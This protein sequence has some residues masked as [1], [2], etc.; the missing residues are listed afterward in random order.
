[1]EQAK[2]PRQEKAP[3]SARFK[4]GITY[5]VNGGLQQI[6]SRIDQLGIK[7][8]VDKMGIDRF[9]NQ[10]A[11]LAAGSGVVTG[12]GGFATMLIGVPV[13]V[14]NVITQQ[15]RVTLAITYHVTG[16]YTVKFED[17]IKVVSSSLKTDA[18]MAVTKNIME[19]VAEKLLAS[20]GSKAAR[21]L[22]PVAG[23]VIGGSV[24][25]FFIKRMADSLLKFDGK[26]A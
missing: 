11:L 17:F 20:V 7:K 13:D 4:K 12:A 6:F 8:G 15:F 24:N 21:R 23:A 19:D 2:L 1:M 5:L 18:G 26:R 14:I 25:Y 22:I 10:C 16:S 9:I 3:L